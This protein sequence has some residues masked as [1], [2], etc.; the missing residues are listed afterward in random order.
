[1][2]Q[3]SL[4]ILLKYRI[5]ARQSTSSIRKN[6][7]LIFNKSLGSK[8]RD[9]MLPLKML[10]L[11]CQQ[12]YIFLILRFWIRRKLFGVNPEGRLNFDFHV[13]KSTRNDAF[14]WILSFHSILV[15]LL[16]LMFHNRTI[17]NR[18]DKI[19]QKVF[20]TCL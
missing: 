7:S 11:K 8:C 1:M 12:I 5:R 13:N 16:V 10:A 20:K 6:V 2:K 4:H 19:H 18:I 15:F 14:S 9:K 17:N 3:Q